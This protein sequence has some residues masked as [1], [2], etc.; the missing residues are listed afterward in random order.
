ME[1]KGEPGGDQEEHGTRGQ[2][3]GGLKLPGLVSACRVARVWD[4]QYRPRGRV[5]G[6][7]SRKVKGKSPEGH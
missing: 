7:E 4:S 1:D 6:N 2:Q 3:V 5:A